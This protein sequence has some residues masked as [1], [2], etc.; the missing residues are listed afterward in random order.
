MSMF[1]LNE[2]GKKKPRTIFILDDLILGTT[3][4]GG[5]VFNDKSKDG[6]DYKW[7][8]KPMET[9][10]QWP[11]PLREMKQCSEAL[12]TVL[13]AKSETIFALI[14]ERP[15]A[16]IP[17]ENDPGSKPIGDALS[18]SVYLSCTTQDDFR[19][20][21]GV[22]KGLKHQL[23]S[24]GQEKS[25]KFNMLN[26]DAEGVIVGPY[27]T[28]HARNSEFALDKSNYY[29]YKSGVGLLSNDL[30]RIQA[31][32]H[33]ETK[34]L[35]GLERLRNVYANVEP[36]KKAD[37]NLQSQFDMAHSKMA[38]YQYI[39]TRLADIIQELSSTCTNGSEGGSVISQYHLSR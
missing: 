37:N 22:Y 20:F 12:R 28:V 11:I 23:I 30:G 5:G 18:S 29:D 1:Q 15:T 10:L 8:I 13:R 6:L 35:A 3:A 14:I 7:A 21:M 27:L 38:S 34:V 2:N 36:D 26:T 33:E 32:M 4:R 25:N 24:S 31:L 17:A 9:R 39:H 16:Y 19:S